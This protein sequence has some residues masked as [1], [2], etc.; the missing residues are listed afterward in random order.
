MSSP[1]EFYETLLAKSKN[2]KRRITIA[3]L[4][5]GTGQME[6]TLVESIRSNII[7]HGESLRVKILL[8]A[9]R[10]SRGKVNSRKILLP[11][12]KHNCKVSLYHTPS[13]RGI[14]HWSMPERWNEVIG[15]QHMK[16]YLFDNSVII[17]GA[18]LSE[19][20]FTNRQDRYVLLEDCEELADFYDDLVEIVSTFSFQLD[21]D[22]QIHLHSTW[23]EHPFHGD[24]N[25]FVLEAR[26]RIEG[27]INS[28]LNPLEG[29]RML[30]ILDKTESSLS[31][32]TVS[33]T[34]IFPLVQMST[35]SIN[36]D[37]RFTTRLF[38][39]VPRDSKVKLASGY[40]NLT[41]EYIDTIIDRSPAS[42]EILTAH[43]EA[44]GFLRASGPAGGIPAAY[45]HIASK[46]LEK[47]AGK[48]QDFRIKLREFR[49]QGW[50]FH[51]KGLWVFRPGNTLP[52]LTLVGSPN[53]GY[54]SVYRDLESQ[55]A[56]ITTNQ[57]LQSSLSEE[58]ENLYRDSQLA[59][60]ETYEQWER[61]VPLW[62]R[63][64]V[65]VVKHYF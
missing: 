49:R 34:W 11:L 46:F 2:A 30:Q 55:I 43:P 25:G 1:K 38:E 35:F 24:F 13:L 60:K 14:L 3:S 52:F 22:D 40:F 16:V 29:E 50:T 65:G 23:T 12:V 26:K 32:P 51:T 56:V 31:E 15:L 9:T 53:F 58:A 61:Y 42:F 5:L 47:V 4:Y 37:S 28:R 54:R 63:G 17:S 8:D 64:V 39:S 10:G 19:D 36:Q 33:D 44:N 6:R 57:D 18:N 21:S 45:T 59:T 48:A 27:L 62:V 20:Y 7:Q 41:E